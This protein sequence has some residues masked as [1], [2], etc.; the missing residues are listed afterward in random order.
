MEYYLLSCDGGVSSAIAV[1]VVKRKTNA[2]HGIRKL[3]CSSLVG[4]FALDRR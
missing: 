3:M 4:A 2:H 1:Y